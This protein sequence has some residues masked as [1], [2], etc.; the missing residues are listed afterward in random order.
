VTRH[1]PPVSD[2]DLQR[3]TV[4]ER[5]PHNA[6]IVLAEYDP[7]WPAMFA[8]ESERILAALGAAALRLEHV[9]STSVPGLVAKP[10]IDMLL[11]VADSADE[12]SYL[13]ALTAAG[14]R[15][16]IREPEWFEHRMFKGPD[17]DVNLHVFSAG[18][19]EIERM[20]TFRDRLRHN[21]PDRD[22]YAAAKRELARRPWRHVQHYADEKSAVVEEIIAR[23]NLDKTDG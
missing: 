15:L 19:A 2:A 16:R 5:V 13:P 7:Q 1:K 22:R 8:R 9:G 11:V 18:A 20:L 17:A 10:I 12:P 4:G 3:V 21:D 14:Y 6:R 23:A